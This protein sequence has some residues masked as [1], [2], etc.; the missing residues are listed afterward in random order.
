MGEETDVHAK[1]KLDDAASEAL[2]HIKEGFEGVKEKAAETGHEMLAMARQAAAVAVG[3]QLSSMIDS[4][5]ELGEESFHAAGELENQTKELAGLLAL[6]DDT[7]ASFEQLQE[8]AGALGDRLED[9]ATNA[10]VLKR[11]VVDAY[12][13]I[14]QRS[15]RSSA[16]ISDMVEKMATA[17]RAL[18]G[19]MQ[20]MGEAWRDLEM[21]FVRPKNA[22]ITMMRQMHVVEGDSRKIA[23]EI[24]AMMQ[25]GKSEEVFKMAEAAVSKMADKM[26]DAPPS[27]E[28][29]VNSIKNIREAMFEM[30]GT[31]M[32]RAITPHLQRLLTYF[33]TH[34]EQFEKL[35]ETIGTKVGE[36]MSGA[37]DKIQAGFEYLQTHADEI[38]SALETGGKALKDAFMFI[39]DHKELLLGLALAFKGGQ[40][41]G[42][43]GN[44]L[45]GPGAGMAGM[46]GRAIGA[47]APSIG[48]EAGGGGN[49]AAM[50]AASIGAAV[51]WAEAARQAGELEKESGMDFTD[52]VGHVLGG[53]MGLTDDLTTA[54]DKLEN[55]RAMAAALDD[56]TN[57]SSDRLNELK[58]KINALA[59]SIEA[60]G[61]SDK[62]VRELEAMRKAAGEKAGAAGALQDMNKSLELAAVAQ[63]DSAFA[64]PQ[65]SLTKRFADVYRQMSG[66][67]AQAAEQAAR[68]ILG[69]NEVLLHALSSTGD[70]EQALKALANM[71]KPGAGGDVAAPHFSLS[72]GG[73]VTIQIH[74]DYRDQDPDRIALVFR[75]DLMKAATASLQ[76]KTALPL[77]M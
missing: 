69:G 33:Q 1:L 59:D 16:Q 26:K 29:V 46:A 73:P 62:I 67:N 66:L 20:R 23:K 68:R 54:S 5:K 38:L 74:Q 36:W 52:A 3:F 22:L 41:L 31:P 18:P 57:Q 34:R 76:A 43:V 45:Q 40:A 9:V 24:N 77:G 11:D 49:M 53:L 60:G 12:E 28:Q 39:V 19:G 15:T 21:G 47:G 37:A 14:A 70:I 56:P 64:G 58:D 72:G 8:K 48:L 13:A 17:S 51:A 50:G 71:I 4:F 7:G 6:T 63:Y 61:A 55:F 2:H 10:G 27:F 75:R 30:M 44:F 42:A 35:A 32:I 25:A 65:L